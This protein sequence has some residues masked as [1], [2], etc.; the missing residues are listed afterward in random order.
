MTAS[1]GVIVI[2]RNEGERL[3][4]C[5]ESVKGLHSVIYVDSSSSDGSVKLARDLG[6]DVVELDM[7]QPF[8]AARARNEGFEFMSR[9]HPAIE[10]V[11]F[12]DGDCEIVEGWVTRAVHELEMKP[13]IAVVAG[14]RRERFPCRS[15][16]N[17]LCDIEWNTPVGQ[18]KACGGDALMRA[19]AFRQVGGYD[20]KVIAGEEPELCV[21]LRANGWVV[22][23]IDAEMTLHDAAMTRFSQW[24]RRMERSG[25]A[26]AQ[27]AA[28]HGRPPEM[29]WVKESRSIL[30]WG[31]LYPVCLLLLAI[32][33]QGWGL[34]LAAA[35]LV[36][37]YRASRHY[38]TRGLNAGQ[39]ALAAFF[40][41]LAK[42]PQT[43]GVFRFHWNGLRSK[44]STLIEYKGVAQ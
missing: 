12:V 20:P 15:L 25:H 4:R 13:E 38:R 34:C 10:F 41:V 24:W 22:Q 17:R 1:V 39:S 31:A 5:L 11:Q 19:A 16:F 7:S 18:A 32:I 36:P 42:F 43:L 37:M 21:R 28:I 27:G 9:Q 44:E 26:Y 23:R 30:F 35:Y 2:G 6:V 3:R 8:S 40:D 14:R 33:T 29:H